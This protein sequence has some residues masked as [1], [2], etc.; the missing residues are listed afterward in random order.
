MISGFN[1]DIEFEG[2]V[3]HVQTEDKGFPASMIMSL[4]YN[5]GTILASKRSTYSDLTAGKFDESEL[6]QRLSRQHKLICAA[7]KAGRIKE[8]SEMTT[9]AAAAK[10]KLEKTPPVVSLPSVARVAPPP[11]PDPVNVTLYEKDLILDKSPIELTEDHLM[12]DGVYVIEDEDI[13]PAEAV[14][15]VSELSGR[16]RPANSKL[17]IEL[18]G[19]TKFKGGDRK[20]VNIL[21]CRGTDRKVVGSAQIMIKVLGSTF[22]PVIFHAKS[23]SNGLARV[24]LQLPHFQAGRAAILIRAMT[25]GEEV[26]LRRAVT[27]G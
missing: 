27:P 20:T 16:D 3:Y 2:T 19:E 25:N 23:D 10:A 18:L 22:R 9:K 7:V 14:A 26:E 12:F 6:A 24:H 11:I 1:T 13:L 4:V 5:R 21:L 8:L 15:V 17:S